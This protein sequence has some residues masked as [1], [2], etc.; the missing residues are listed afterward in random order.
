MQA[1]TRLSDAY[2]MRSFICCCCWRS[3]GRAHFLYSQA[4]LVWLVLLV[5]A[6]TQIDSRFTHM[7]LLL[8][9]LRSIFSD[10]TRYTKLIYV[11][12]NM[13]G[14]C[15][16]LEFFSFFSLPLIWRDSFM[17]AIVETLFFNWHLN[18]SQRVS[19]GNNAQNAM[20]AMTRWNVFNID[21]W[22]L[23]FELNLSFSQFNRKDQQK[24]T[25]SIIF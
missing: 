11:F 18:F 2:L 15:E 14:S 5:S 6:S 17:N 8:D 13:P 20:R 22:D 10:T 12:D 9:Y 1:L 19:F 3:F 4:F 23:S 25:R 7:S 24:T 21:K 16:Q